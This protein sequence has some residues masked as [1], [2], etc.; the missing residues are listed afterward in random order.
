MKGWTSSNSSLPIQIRLPVEIQP[1]S[2][3]LISSLWA[4]QPVTCRPFVEPT[5]IA[6]VNAQI[7][8]LNI[9]VV[10]AYLEWVLHNHADPY[11]FATELRCGP[12]LLNS[13]S[14]AK[15]LNTNMRLMKTY[16]YNY[17]TSKLQSKH[18]VYVFLVYVDL[19]AETAMVTLNMVL[20]GSSTSRS[21]QILISQIPCGTTYT[22]PVGCL[23]WYTT[24]TGTLTSFG[25][26]FSSTPAVQK[27]ANQD[28]VICIRTSQVISK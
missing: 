3:W 1:L 27:I 12:H 14:S 4:M 22:A 9:V 15:Y 8:S 18:F 11:S 10:A 28:Y 6:I 26:R 13:I 23:Q 2:A 17:I 20:T 25:Y 21:W 7:T 19:S 5:Q 16:N 24:A